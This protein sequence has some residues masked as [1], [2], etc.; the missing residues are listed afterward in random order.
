MYDISKLTNN[1][2][3]NKIILSIY[4]K[5]LIIKNHKTTVLTYTKQE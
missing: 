3:K 1:I 2:V 5:I 4:F